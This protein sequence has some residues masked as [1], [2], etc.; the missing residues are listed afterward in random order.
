MAKKT[1]L[2]FDLFA[3][4][5]SISLRRITA[6]ILVLVLVSF[7]SVSCAT[8]AIRATGLQSGNSVLTTPIDYHGDAL[9]FYSG[10]VSDDYPGMTVGDY[11]GFAPIDKSALLN[12]AAHVFLVEESKNGLS[13]VVVYLGEKDRAGTGVGT[14]LKS[15]VIHGDSVFVEENIIAKDG[16][17]DIYLVENGNIVTEH[18]IKEINVTDGYAVNLNTKFDEEGEKL[19]LTLTSPHK[20]WVPKYVTSLV[21]YAGQDGDG[22]PIW[23]ELES[24]DFSE[25]VSVEFTL[26]PEG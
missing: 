20:F 2:E 1:N 15:T 12:E 9:S 6:L 11:I 24:G 7:I 23:Y 17:I 8:N 14:N 13:I 18:N 26:V 10:G 5:H 21:V 4:G 3:N 25:S 16:G 22:S 19:L